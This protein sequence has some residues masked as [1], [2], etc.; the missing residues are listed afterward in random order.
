[1]D[2]KLIRAIQNM[3]IRQVLAK[4]CR[5]IDRMDRDL[6]E[7]CFW[8]AEGTSFSIVCGSFRG[9]PQDWIDYV[10]ARVQGDLVTTHHISQSLIVTAEDEGE[11]ETYFLARHAYEEDG[12]VAIMAVAGRYADKL[13]ARAGAWRIARREVIIDLR[14]FGR[15]DAPA[16]VPSNGVSRRRADDPSFALSRLGRAP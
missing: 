3:E 13:E 2:P 12:G 15:T 1:M 8:P 14:Q 16:T 7:S 4:Y 9:S 11:A 10:F 6:V 5:G